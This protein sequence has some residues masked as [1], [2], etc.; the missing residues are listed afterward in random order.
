M[1]RIKY[2]KKAG[3]FLRNQID[4]D[5][6]I[7][8]DINLN[9]DYELY[10]PLSAGS[11]RELNSDIYDYIEEKSNLIPCNIP[12]RIRFH[13]RKFSDD[14]Q[15]NIREIIGRHYA[16][17]AIDKQW[18]IMSNTKK[19]IVMS[20]FGIAMLMTYFYLSVFV[21]NQ[22]AVEIFS[23]LGSFSLWEAAGSFLIERPQLKRE[24]NKIMQFKNQTIEFYNQ[25]LN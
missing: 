4:G 17:A 21:R 22:I 1:S 9:N 12:L 24:Y 20:V 14:E 3:A 23:V 19:L 18:D 7:S 16:V 8:I 2:I 6:M 15:N 13:G 25:T 10:N 11:D 5:G